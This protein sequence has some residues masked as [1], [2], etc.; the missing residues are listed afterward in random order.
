MKILLL[1]ILATTFSFA[2]LETADTD[3]GA[4]EFFYGLDQGFVAEANNDGWHLSFKTGFIAGT[5]RANKNVNV[6]EATKLAIEDFGTPIEEADLADETKFKAVVN[7]NWDWKLGAFNIG[8]QPEEAANFGWGEYFQGDGI[9]GFK[10][11]VLE[12]LNNGAKTYKQ[13]AINSMSGGAYNISMANLDGTDSKDMDI[14]KSEFDGKMFGYFNLLTEE[15]IDAQPAENAWDIYIGTY[16]ELLN[17]GPAG[18]VPYS[19][20]GFLTNEN[21]RVA[22]QDNSLSSYPAAEDYSFE[23]NA[24]GHDWKSLNSDFSGY[25][26]DPISYFVQRTFVNGD[27]ETVG[28]GPVYKIDFVSYEGFQE[29][30]VEFEINALSTSVEASQDASLAL[31]PNVTS[32]NSSI[33]LVYD[34]SGNHNAGIYNSFGEKVLDLDL[35]GNGRLTEKSINLPNLSVGVYFVQL[36][37]NSVNQALKFIVK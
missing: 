15:V 31:Y 7:E 24:I 36:N 35:I 14:N 10:L 4:K 8:G 13:F 19:V 17:A 28:D 1:L 25:D 12:I 23:N 37:N 26:M 30:I 18:M 2:K 33:T 34:L 21:I 6:F 20:V 9:Y 3:N 29:D 27:G 16:K 11:Y 32:S 5:I 22:E